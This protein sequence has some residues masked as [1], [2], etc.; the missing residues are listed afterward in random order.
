MNGIGKTG[1]TQNRDS[2]SIWRVYMPSDVDREVYIKTCFLTGTVT[3]INEGSEI[4]HRVKVGK[5]TL[6]SIDFPIDLDS[7]GSEVVCLSLPYSGQLRVVDV[8]AS[9][10]EYNDQQENEYRFYKKNDVGFAELKIDGNGKILLSVDSEDVADITIS[11]TNKDRAGKF[12][13]NVNGELNVINDGTTLIQST[14][15]IQ[16]EQIEGEEKTSVNIAKDIVT[17]STAKLVI[18]SDEE[19][20]LLGNKTIDTILSPLL[21]QLSIESAGPYPLLNQAK[22]AEIK[23]KLE[24]IKSKKSFLD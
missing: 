24:N 16:L 2:I 15:N 14:G 6:Q 12:N 23:S 11:V 1:I 21:D 22:Y 8:F 18:N 17:I 7:L 10:S 3:L 5:L 4:V 20:M 13:L 9:S 19:P